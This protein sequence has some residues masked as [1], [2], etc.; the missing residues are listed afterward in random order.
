MNREDG[1]SN[2]L[3]IINLYFVFRLPVNAWQIEN[4]AVEEQSVVIN[5][6]HKRELKK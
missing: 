3:N 4:R 6:N 1:I 5:A 2:E